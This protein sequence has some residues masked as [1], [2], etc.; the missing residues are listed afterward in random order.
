MKIDGV[1]Y[2]SVWVDREEGWSVRIF[3]QT[4]LP[5]AVEI[6]RLA[7]E[8]QVAHAIRAMQVRGAPLIGAVAAYGVALAL[9]KDASTGNLDGPGQLRL[10]EDAD[11]PAIL[12]VHPHAAIGDAVYLH[13]ISLCALPLPRQ[14]PQTPAPASAGLASRHLPRAAFAASAALG[15]RRVRCAGAARRRG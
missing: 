1:P 4:K 11:R 8:E 9:R 2:R 12:P 10:V 3:D 6:L 14:R 15:G 5:W 7:D 13:R